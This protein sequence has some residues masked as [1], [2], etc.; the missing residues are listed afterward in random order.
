MR[1]GTEPETVYEATPPVPEEVVATATSAPEPVVVEPQWSPESAILVTEVRPSRGS[2][3]GGEAVVIAGSGFVEPM[4]V[5]IGGRPAAGVEVLNSTT[6]RVLTP[7]GFIGGVT[8]EVWADG[9][10]TAPAEGLFAYVDQPARVVMAVRPTQGTVSGGTAITIVGTGFEDGA[11]VVLGGERAL[12]VEVMDANRIMAITPPHEEGLV[13]LVVRNPGMPAAVLAE[14]FEFAPG[15]EVTSVEPTA[16]RM[17]GGSVVTI[18][19]AGFLPGATVTFNG[20]PALV[21]EVI[22]DARIQAVAP[23]GELG[24]A[25]V[26]VINVD[27][28][29]AVLPDVMSFVLPPPESGDEDSAGP[30]AE[31]AAG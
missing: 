5:R 3:Q 13:D 30:G 2:T 24:P 20:V 23:S 10:A 18:T 22:D 11:R 21:V 7:A 14:A 16:V 19:G 29:P 4:V 28:P 31:V 27:E 25:V 1:S 12:E 9:Q 26:S 8:V 15:P 6:A 17:D